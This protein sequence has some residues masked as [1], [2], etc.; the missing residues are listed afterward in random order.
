MILAENI[1]MFF[2]AI[3]TNG[4]GGRVDKWLNVAVSQKPLYPG[5][6]TSSIHGGSAALGRQ[7]GWHHLPSRAVALAIKP[8][9]NIGEFVLLNY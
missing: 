9:T 4:D 6:P 8:S 2:N 1:V 5:I 3:V 7:L